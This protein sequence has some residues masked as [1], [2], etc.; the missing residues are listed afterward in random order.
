MSFTPFLHFDGCAEEA[1]TFYADVF[2][3]TDLQIMRFSE[4][5]EGTNMAPSNRVMF[6]QFTRDGHALGAWDFPEGMEARPQQS[7]SVGH[8][9]ETVARGTEVFKCLAEGGT[10]TMPFGPNFFSDGFGM[11]TDR[12]GTN[13]VISVRR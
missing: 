12:F 7:V 8:E 13:W 4:A 9:V 3:A 6:S 11:L 2:G 5:P 10:V 1:M